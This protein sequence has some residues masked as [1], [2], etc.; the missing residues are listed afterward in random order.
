MAVNLAMKTEKR[1]HAMSYNSFKSN[2]C[3]ALFKEIAPIADR[4]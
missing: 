2:C 1:K 4:L 3:T